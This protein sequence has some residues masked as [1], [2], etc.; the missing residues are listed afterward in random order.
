MKRLIVLITIAFIV[1]LQ[2]ELANAQKR[3][4]KKPA[5]TTAKPTST[6]EPKPAAKAVSPAEAFFNEGLKC[7]AK[8][9][10]CQVSN[11]TKATNLQI[12][13]KAAFQK[14]A[15]A[16]MGREDFEK[17]I[18]DLTKVIELDL[19]DATGFKS[20]GKAYLAMPRT[21][22]N[23]RNAIS[24]FTSAIDLEPKDAES[25]NLRGSAYLSIGNSEKGNI[26]L[27]KSLSFAPPSAENFIA[28]GDAFM[29]M[30]DYD[31]AIEAYGKAIGV[32]S[33][34]VEAY[35][36]R[37]K[38][39]S[40]QQNFT[41]A[42]TDL[43]RAVEIDNSKPEAFL[44]RAK[45]YETVK[46]FEEA[47]KD[48][49]A[50]IALD[51]KDGFKYLSRGKILFHQKKLDQALADFAL[52]TQLKPN[53]AKA[54]ASRCKVKHARRDWAEAVK[55]CSIAIELDPTIEDAYILRGKIIDSQSRA[56]QPVYREQPQPAADRIRG[57][58]N[59]WLNANREIEGGQGSANVYL[60]RASGYSANIADYANFLTNQE[61]DYT[62]A[63]NL[64]P[65]L[66][67]A[68]VGRARTR[69]YQQNKLGAKQDMRRAIELEGNNLNLTLDDSLYAIWYDDREIIDIA[70]KNNPDDLSLLFWRARTFSGSERETALKLILDKY[71]SSNKSAKEREALKDAVDLLAGLADDAVRIKKS[72]IDAGF[73][74]KL[75]VI[76][77]ALKRWVD[78]PALYYLRGALMII[79]K[80]KGSE[81]Y[82]TKAYDLETEWRYGL[83]T[84]AAEVS[85]PIPAQTLS[86]LAQLKREKD[87]DIRRL[88]DAVANG[89]AL[90]RSI[91]F[92]TDRTS[93][94]ESTSYNILV[95]LQE[96]ISAKYFKA[97]IEQ[98][99]K[100]DA[101]M[102][103]MYR[104]MEEISAAD[105]RRRREAKAKRDAELIEAIGGAV[106]TVVQAVTQPK[107]SPSNQTS[108]PTRQ[109]ATAP[110]TNPSS[111]NGSSTG[112]GPSVFGDIFV[113]PLGPDTCSRGATEQVEHCWGGWQ[114]S[115]FAQIQFR[116]KG[117]IADGFNAINDEPNRKSFRWYVDFKNTSNAMVWFPFELIYGDGT[118][119][120]Y[121]GGGMLI[122]PGE[123]DR[124][125]DAANHTFSD[126]ATLRVRVA[127]LKSCTNYSTLNSGSQKGYRC[128]EK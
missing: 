97:A 21:S 61:K 100:M 39:Y 73:R 6:P 40:M 124:L 123:T 17:A 19:N 96:E 44:E 76:D 8:D 53:S 50:A 78:V 72:S 70:L 52:A 59:M 51:S 99:E 25:Y 82:F 26:D 60:R 45:I 30:K 34:K 12:N 92:D 24:D 64:D 71:D 128:N 29:K 105:A 42:L 62:T 110:T 121:K 7:D 5:A 15:A 41:M 93:K 118:I 3:S 127:G 22:Q 98:Q 111:G 103:K 55:D 126:S 16:Y 35:I 43:S 69:L 38:A 75:E 74:A 57:R 58:V 49:D 2:A 112:G 108:T 48:Y 36:K 32:N 14:R 87:V 91:S 66:V 65:S 63:I 67:D 88:T 102:A 20:R 56:L 89:G 46:K 68:Y 109:T 1:G 31:K 113:T 85:I 106:T 101:I 104:E 90:A 107:S 79:N 81:F 28:R 77:Q 95:N 117:P 33:K 115:G 86:H 125:L 119:A 80:I 54:Y 83:P 11:Y 94:A 37:S 9:Y 27:D 47:L 13:T 4:V 23:I 122:G 120:D 84:T 116:V 10:D 18:A 114:A